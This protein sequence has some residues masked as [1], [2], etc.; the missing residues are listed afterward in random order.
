MKM[1]MQN[2]LFQPQLQ[3]FD[4]AEFVNPCWKHTVFVHRTDYDGC[5]GPD[6][7]S[8]LGRWFSSKFQTIYREIF[9]I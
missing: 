6:G 7:L 4:G 9:K 1:E 2:I 5:R 3:I 8:Y